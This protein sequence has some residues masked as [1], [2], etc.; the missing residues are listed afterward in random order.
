LSHGIE[1]SDLVRLPCIP[2]MKLRFGVAWDGDAIAA[3]VL[4]QQGGALAQGLVLALQPGH[5][6]L[7]LR[8][9][10]RDKL[11]HLLPRKLVET[12]E[13]CQQ[14]NQ[15]PELAAEL[16]GLANKADPLQILGPVDAILAAPPGLGQQP[17]LLVET[18]SLWGGA[19]Q[20]GKFADI[21]G[22]ARKG[23][24]KGAHYRP[25]AGGNESPWGYDRA[26]PSGAITGACVLVMATTSKYWVIIGKSINP[27]Y[28]DT[29]EPNRV[30]RW[31][32]RAPQ[33]DFPILVY[34]VDGLYAMV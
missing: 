8:Q 33:G 15:L 30:T 16:L 11:F 34:V 24:V 28:S 2:L 27:A 7:D 18:D 1:S 9:L 10:A 14:G 31:P 13:A 23:G 21:H 12:G 26:D 25:V 6:G 17:D 4:R 22:A 32:E 29:G 20:P 3:G 5:V 19:R